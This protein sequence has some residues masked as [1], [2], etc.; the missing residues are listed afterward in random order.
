MDSLIALPVFSKVMFESEWFV[1]LAVFIISILDL[2]KVRIVDV[3]EAMAVA[4]VSLQ[5]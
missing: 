5:K 1:V 4:V 3:F 2:L